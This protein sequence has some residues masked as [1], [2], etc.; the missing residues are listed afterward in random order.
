MLVIDTGIAA[1]VT[2][3]IV[4]IIIISCGSGV[5]QWIEQLCAGVLY[6]LHLCLRTTRISLVNVIIW[7]IYTEKKNGTYTIG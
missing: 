4:V 1:T 5:L 3:I 6:K 7:N 2:V